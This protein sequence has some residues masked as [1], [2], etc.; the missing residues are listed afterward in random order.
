MSNLR[1]FLPAA[2]WLLAAATTHSAELAILG[3]DN[4]S[5]YAPQ[6][7]EVDAIYG[8]VVLR[9]DK[10]VAVIAQAVSTRNANMGIKNVGGCLIDF[11]TRDNP[12]D[13][14]ACYYPLAKTVAW[15]TLNGD[16]AFTG[17]PL[18]PNSRTAGVTVSAVVEEGKLT[19]ETSYTLEDGADHLVVVTRLTNLTGEP[20]AYEPKFELATQGT[21]SKGTTGPLTWAY[22]RWWNAAYGVAAVATGAEPA[23][24]KV[25]AGGKLERTYHVRVA[26]DLRHLL[27][28]AIPSTAGKTGHRLLVVDDA[29]RPIA[30][31][32]VAVNRD[33]K[34]VNAGLSGGHGGFR[35]DAAEGDAVSVS[36]P[37]YG[38]RKVTLAAG[39]ETK[40]VFPKCGTA[41]GVVTNESGG[42]IPCKVQFRGTGETKD[43]V[44]FDKTGEHA[45]GNLYYAH[46]GK[47]SI[48]LP[49]GT[50]NC[51]VSY[52]PEY[53]VVERPLEIKGG[54]TAAFDARLIRSVDTRGWI[55]ADFHSHSSPSGDNNSSQFGRVLNLLCEHIEFAPCT[56]H[57]RISTY[58]PHLKRLQVDNLLATCTGMELTSTPLPISHLNAFPLHMHEHTQDGG[59]PLPDT[60]P[61]VQIERLAFWDNR[62]EKLVQQ[63]HPDIGWLFYDKNGDGKPDAGHA[64]GVP[65]IDVMEVHPPQS[66]FKAPVSKN[67]R[68]EMSNNRIVNWLQLLN[69]GKRIPGVVNTDAHY[70]IHGSGWLRNWIASPTDDPAKIQTLD[71]VR[72]SEKG[73]IVMS[74]GPFLTASLTVA[75]GTKGAAYGPGDEVAATD[76]KASLIVRVQCPNWFDVDRVQVFVNGAADPKLNF[77]RESTPEAFSGSVVKFDREIPLSFSGDAHVIV[78]TIGERSGLGHVMGIEHAKTPPVA[79]TNPIYVDVDGNGF[80]PNLDTLGAPL[81]VKS[82]TSK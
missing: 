79:V 7:K 61:D 56:E 59:A 72:A 36:H 51:T 68:G 11:T 70:N 28:A 5:A 71:V 67:S 63:N 53:D 22:D 82:S 26:A 37:S 34:L 30:G 62:S 20:I 64:K 13:Q 78:A 35:F 66:I 40:V 75:G 19:A 14:L 18:N 42:P 58:V 27:V 2:L 23:P 39:G 48:D 9:N 47:I 29:D 60:D 15:R 3:P 74:N 25:P 65:H 50:Y 57:N 32:Y 52:G 8:D 76:G 46:D 55:S 80:K 43:P 81:P 6:G 33:D 1:S 17:E 12:N 4:W 77:T 24:A 10:L 44:F 21:W 45:V 73:R 54:E 49:A 69:Q 38:E 41:A 16:P 31:A